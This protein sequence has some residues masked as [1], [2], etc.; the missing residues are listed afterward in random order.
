MNAAP[1]IDSVN[2]SSF[3]PT[4]PESTKDEA[5]SEF[6]APGVVLLRVIRRELD[7]ASRLDYAGPSVPI[8]I[9]RASARRERMAG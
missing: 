7:A 1:N 2:L 4:L 5:G 3:D 8:R 9:K 6:I